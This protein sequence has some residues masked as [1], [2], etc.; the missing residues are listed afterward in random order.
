[1]EDGTVTE[2]LKQIDNKVCDEMYAP[3]GRKLFKVGLG[4]S[5]EKKKITE[6]KVVNS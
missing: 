1:M 3:D 4:F 5:S 2:A 6:Y